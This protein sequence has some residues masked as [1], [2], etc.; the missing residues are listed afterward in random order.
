MPVDR[1]ARGLTAKLRCHQVHDNCYMPALAC[2][3]RPLLRVGVPAGQAG[4][5]LEVRVPKT[6]TEVGGVPFVL[7]VNLRFLPGIHI[8]FGPSGA[9]KSTLLDCIA[10][11]LRPEEGRIAIGNHVLLDVGG[12]VN[13][14]APDFQPAG[15]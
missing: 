7:D 12:G 15:G 11:L 5:K 4:P 14:P 6:R 1:R 10:G 9:G 2:L 8:L 3:P 13:V